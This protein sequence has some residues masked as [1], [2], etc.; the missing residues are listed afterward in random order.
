[1]SLYMNMFGF[2][3]DEL[4]DIIMTI[5]RDTTILTIITLDKSQAE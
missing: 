1:V 2:D 3:D 5:A 4:N